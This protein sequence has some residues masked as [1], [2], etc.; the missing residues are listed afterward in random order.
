MLKKWLLLMSVMIALPSAAQDI[1]APNPQLG[2][3]S[4]TVVD[5]NGDSVPGATATLEGLVNRER[6]RCVR[7][8]RYQA[9]SSLSSPGH[10]EWFP[11][12]EFPHDRPQSGPIR[13]LYDGC[14]APAFWTREFGH[15]LRFN[16]ASRG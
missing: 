2:T 10:G 14:K 15:R 4:G 11:R 1:S 3:V 6:F 12:M 7:I 9:R 16:A 8:P 5:L 13:L